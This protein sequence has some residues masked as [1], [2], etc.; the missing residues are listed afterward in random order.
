MWCALGNC[1]KRLDRNEDAIRCFEQAA[2]YDDHEGVAFLELARLY[3]KQ[4]EEGQLQVG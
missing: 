4:G 3:R 2:Q 1:Y